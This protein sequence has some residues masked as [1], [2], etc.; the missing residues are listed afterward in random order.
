MQL[1]RIFDALASRPRREILAFLS[2]NELTT[3]DLAARFG[4]SAPAI[5]RHLS[6]LD[7]AGLVTSRRQGQHVFYAMVPHNLV[8]T[9]TG[10]AFQVCPVAGH[11]NRES[12]ELARRRKPRSRGCPQRRRS[13]E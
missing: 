4:M 6:V 13:R 9:L 5:S 8:K 10:I 2:K 7:N 1:D 11:Y 12:R 3:S